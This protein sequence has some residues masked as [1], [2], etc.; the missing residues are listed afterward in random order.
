MGELRCNPLFAAGG[1]GPGP[2]DRRYVQTAPK[3]VLP[4]P[5]S[6]AWGFRAEAG[7]ARPLKLRTLVG[8]R[9]SCGQGMLENSA[10]PERQSPSNRTHTIDAI[11]NPKPS[12]LNP[13]QDSLTLR[14]SRLSPGPG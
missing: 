2:G 6:E 11:L 10:A 1:R 3:S 8:S 9:L 4:T 12:T 13:T 7:G 14:N 5:L